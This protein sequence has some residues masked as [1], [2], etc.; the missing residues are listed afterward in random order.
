MVGGLLA[1]GLVVGGANDLHQRVHH[2]REHEHPKHQTQLLGILKLIAQPH[3]AQDEEHGGGGEPLHQFLPH[4]AGLVVTYG[5]RD[6]DKHVHQHGGSLGEMLIAAEH[7]HDD[8]NHHHRAAD[9]QES[10]HES[11]G[12][13]GGHQDE[14][15]HKIH[16]RSLADPS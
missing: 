15:I 10:A 9:A 6:G 12:Q 11:S 14:L 5:R 1:A 8:G 13:A 7:V 4:S 16:A 2:F 3:S